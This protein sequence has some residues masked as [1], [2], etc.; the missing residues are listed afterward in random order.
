[1]IHSTLKSVNRK[2]IDN[3]RNWPDVLDL[4]TFYLRK[5]LIEFLGVFELHYGLET[6]Y[7]VATLKSF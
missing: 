4:A 2:C 6:P 7:I 1:M 3:E 5:C